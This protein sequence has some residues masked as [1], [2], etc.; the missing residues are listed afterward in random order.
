[1]QDT[2]SASLVLIVGA[3]GVAYWWYH[4][5]AGKISKGGPAQQ[6]QGGTSGAAGGAPASPTTQ[7]S[8]STQSDTLSRLYAFA[9]RWGLTVTSGYRPGANSLHGEGRAVDVAVPS[10]S[11]QSQVKAAAAAAGIYVYPETAGQIGANGSVSTGTHWHLSFPEI[12]N[13]SEVF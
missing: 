5:T 10:P 6:P 13:G 7:Q 3:A 2:R 1:M 11:I 8:S 9:Q 12:R 4:L